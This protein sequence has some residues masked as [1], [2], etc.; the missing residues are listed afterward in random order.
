MILQP[1]KIIS[2]LSIGHGMTVLDMGSSIGFWT[3]P[4][5]EQVG[6]SGKIIAVDFHPEIIERLNHDAQEM[7]MTNIHGITGDIHKLADMPIKHESVDRVLLIRMIS[8]I[9]QDIALRVAELLNYA[10]PEGKLIIIDHIGYK[11]DVMRALADNTTITV[12]DIARVSEASDEHFFGV[13]VAKI[14]S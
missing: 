10:K 8:V 6:P 9:E 12:S 13:M 14:P 5:S 7:G 2:A 1:S 11:E 4:L 3:K